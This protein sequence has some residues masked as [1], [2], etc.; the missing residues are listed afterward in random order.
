MAAAPSVWWTA[1]R[2]GIRAEDSGLPPSVRPRADWGAS[3]PA[4][5]MTAHAID[6]VTIHHTGPPA[7]YGSPPA[8]AYLRVIQAFHA[9]VERG[10]PDIAYHLLID[11]DGLV[12]QG[13]SLAY[14]GDSAT[15][16]DPTGHALVAVLGDYDVQIPSPAQVDA[17][18]TIVRWLIEA[19]NVKPSRVGAHRDYVATACPGRYLYTL[20]DGLRD[21]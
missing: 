21:G 11:L 17:L 18:Q 4:G 7:W 2:L 3:P 15:A 5:G 1:A 10:W 12:W 9:G 19:H 20:I 8:P 6:R 14:A 16:Y 13:R